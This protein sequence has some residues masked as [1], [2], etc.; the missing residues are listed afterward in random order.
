MIHQ[1]SHTKP[2]A[3]WI[4]T[5]THWYCKA[6]CWLIDRLCVL[7]IV[8]LFC[9]KAKKCHFTLH[10]S[11]NSSASAGSRTIWMHDGYIYIYV[12]AIVDCRLCSMRAAYMDVQ[13][14][15][16]DEFEGRCVWTMDGWLVVS[17]T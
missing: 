13:Y 15:E 9:K 10:K 7:F 16:Y 14:V 11:L 12:A 8:C 17:S 2:D 5:I 1:K 4:F 3:Q 6:V